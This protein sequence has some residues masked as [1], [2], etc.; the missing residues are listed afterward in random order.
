MTSGHLRLDRGAVVGYKGSDWRIVAGINATSLWLEAPQ[1][2][3]DSKRPSQ[4]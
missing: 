2:T 4:N 1:H 3:H